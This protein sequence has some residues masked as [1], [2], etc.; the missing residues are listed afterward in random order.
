[1]DVMDTKTL[2]YSDYAAFARLSA[3]ELAVRTT[4]VPTGIVVVSR[5]SRSQYR[6]RQLCLQKIRE[7]LERRARPP[8]VRHKTKPT[9]GSKE[10]RLASKRL[11]SQVKQL[12]R[13]PAE[14]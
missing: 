7:E 9:R 2:T 11:R 13:R 14:E 6:N 4:H 8:K 10:R 3:D 1:M 12:R 5:E